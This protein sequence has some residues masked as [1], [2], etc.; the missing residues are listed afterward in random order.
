MAATGAGPAGAAELGDAVRRWA[1][2]SLLPPA[3][4]AFGALLGPPPEYPWGDGGQGRGGGRCRGGGATGRGKQRA[5]PSTNAAK[6]RTAGGGGGGGRWRGSIGRATKRWAGWS[7]CPE[8]A[9]S[10]ARGG[11]VTPGSGSGRPLPAGALCPAAA[12][13]V[14]VPEHPELHPIPRQ[15]P[16]KPIQRNHRMSRWTRDDQ[17]GFGANDDF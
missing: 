2:D 11:G 3:P 16:V 8:S 14:W 1:A 5:E 12:P 6:D 4:R 7:G 17:E 15:T 13:P 10:C 9:L